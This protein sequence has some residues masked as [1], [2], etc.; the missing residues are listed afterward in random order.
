MPGATDRLHHP[1]VLATPG[2]TTPVTALCG[3]QERALIKH[4]H[5]DPSRIVLVGR[6]FGDL[7]APRGASAEHRLAAM[8]ADPGQLEMGSAVMPHAVCGSMAPATVKG[9][10]PPKTRRPAARHH[11]AA[12]VLELAGALPE[13]EAMSTAVI[14][15]AGRAGQIVRGLLARGRPTAGHMVQIQ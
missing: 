6:S 5:I 3:E 8:I 9:P 10:D 12:H 2:R 4:P 13:G 14:G 7:I 11:G 15:A 1:P